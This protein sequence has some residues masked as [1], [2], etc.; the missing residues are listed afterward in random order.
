MGYK[1]TTHSFRTQPQRYDAFIQLRILP[2][3]IHAAHILTHTLTHT[4]MKHACLWEHIWYMWSVMNQVSYDPQIL[5]Q[6]YRAPRVSS[7]CICESSKHV[8]SVHRATSISL[9]ISKLQLRPLLIHI[10]HT[11]RY[12]YIYTPQSYLLFIQRK[13]CAA[14]IYSTDST[15]LIPFYSEKPRRILSTSCW[16]RTTDLRVTLYLNLRIA[17]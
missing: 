11:C 12:H 2:Y 15:Q 1:P 17:L 9:C 10:T 13:P 3:P 6:C 8:S 5:H 16:I 4:H 14:Y 7:I